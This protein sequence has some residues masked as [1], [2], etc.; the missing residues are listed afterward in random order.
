[1]LSTHCYLEHCDVNIPFDNL[2]IH[3]LCKSKLEIE[4]PSLFNMNRLI[5][6]VVSS[7][8]ASI[9]FGGYLNCDLKEF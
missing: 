9:R 5:S 8:T 2:A 7:L 3:N 1:M 4:R 6:K